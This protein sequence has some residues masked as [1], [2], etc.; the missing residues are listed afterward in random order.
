M[1]TPAAA[2]D[3]L[4]RVRARAPLVQCI[5]NFVAMDLAA[6]LLL[7]IGASPAMVHAEEEASE[8]A[9]IA[10]ALTINIGTISPL[11]V[12]GMQSAATTA[13]QIGLPWVLDPVGCGATRWR[14]GVARDL[15]ARRPPLIRGNASEIIALAADRAAATRGVDASDPVEAAQEAARTLARTHGGVVAVTG[16]ADFIT[17]GCRDI[18]VH[19][20]DALMTRVT[21]MGCALTAV[22]G[23]FLAVEPDPL[24]A[25]AAALA[26]FKLAGGR[27]AQG[28]AGPGSLRWRMADELFR[29]DPAEVSAKAAIKA[30]A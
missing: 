20:G 19:G 9:A 16:A 27:A 13:G 12:R 21:A 6:N 2:A 5:T 8:F 7:A 18:G 4:E 28:A 30:L 24:T 26:V 11:W 15:A 29:L 25:S 3:I 23:A 14:T 1:T 17:D 10:S 22:C